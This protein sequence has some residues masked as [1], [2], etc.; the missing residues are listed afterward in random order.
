[1]LVAIDSLFTEHDPGF[2]HPESPQRIVALQQMLETLPWRS[3]LQFVP[4]SSASWTEAE[5]VHGADYLNSLRRLRGRRA[6]LDPD[7]VAS[8]RSVEVA[9]AAAGTALAVAR[10][11]AKSGTTGFAMVRPPG[12]HAERERAM[13]FCLLN[14]IAIAAEWAL[15]EHGS[16]KVA[17]IDFDVH[18]GNGTQHS[19]YDRSDVLYLS[20]HQYPFYPGTGD[21]NETGGGEGKGFTVNFP[22]AAGTG[23]DL[24]LPIYTDLV[25]AIL[26][27]FGPDWI[28]VSAGYDAHRDDPLA[29]IQ[30]S[31][32]GFGVVV[33]SLQRAAKEL[34][35]G[36]IVYLLEGGYNLAALS[37]CVRQ[38]L[39]VM[40]GKHDATEPLIER[41][42]VWNIYRR[43]AQAAH[44]HWKL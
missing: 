34:C 24:F 28:F 10:E 31:T 12:H 37:A 7:T 32:R 5:W 33:Q 40:L 20:S 6:R 18:H 23:E 22:L 1:M 3:Q 43:K 15:R 11:A 21:W 36:R 9:L 30:I 39:Q 4:V 29:Q 38:S 44:S 19:F 35:G 26:R 25:P 13:G 42:E 8:A 27:R 2:G 41:S 17:V 16:R 14:N